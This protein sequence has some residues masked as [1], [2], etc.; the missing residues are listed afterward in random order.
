[1]LKDVGAESGCGCCCCPCE[2][3][4]LFLGFPLQPRNIYRISLK[5]RALS[6]YF[7]HTP[8]YQY[9]SSKNSLCFL[10]DEIK[11]K[12]TCLLTLCF[13]CS[14]LCVRDPT[15]LL[16][17]VWE[18]VHSAGRSAAPPA[19]SHR[20]KAVQVQS[21]RENLHRHVHLAQTRVGTLPLR[22]RCGRQTGGDV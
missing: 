5:T 11:A 19:H 22:C 16:W 17:A 12:R 21:L 18:N 14:F 4:E 8:L 1:M 10:P 2:I 9:G 7:L 3:R 13:L 20:G 6:I 15:V